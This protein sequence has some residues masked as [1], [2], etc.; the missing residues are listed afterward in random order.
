MVGGAAR[1][2]FS[3]AA[4]E[5]AGLAF[6]PD[7]RRLDILFLHANGFNALTCRSILAPLGMGMHVLA[8]DMRGHGLTRLP[9]ETA[10]HSWRVYRDDLLALLAITGVP[11]VLAGHSMGGA[12]AVLA[13]PHLPAATKLVLFDPV[14]APVA[15]YDA[16]AVHGMGYDMPIAQGALR[17]KPNFESREAAFT[18]YRGRG[19]F[20]TWPDA[21]LRDYVQDGLRALPEGGFTLSCAPAWEAANFA[22]AGMVNPYMALAE[23][24]CRTHVLK[25]DI[26]PICALTEAQLDAATRAR[27]RIETVA[28]SSH[29]LPMERPDVVRRA[30]LNALE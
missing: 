27:V 18:A 1:R 10:G 20:T 11:R 24:A 15:L 9:T 2:V 7:E 23:T 3:L 30:L 19:A 26:A 5:M 4:G 17:R 29:F 12:T 21:V 8:V 6:G 22:A 14:L 25:A 28:G 16:A 13:S